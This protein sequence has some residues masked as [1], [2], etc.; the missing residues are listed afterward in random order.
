MTKVQ[1]SM[2]KINGTAIMKQQVF[3]FSGSMIKAVALSLAVF[4]SSA[5]QA[6][7]PV[8][9]GLS[10]TPLFLGFT[11][12]PNVFFVSDDSGSMDWEFMTPPHWRWYN[13]DSD[14]LRAGAWRDE[15]LST[16][17]TNGVLNSADFSSGSTG[18]FNGGYGYIFG[19]SD[20]VY[21]DYRNNN[22]ADCSSGTAYKGWTENCAGGGNHPLDV[23]WRGRA[24][25]LN[26]VYYN[27]NILYEPWDGP[28]D[29]AGTSCADARFIAARSN[30]Y[31]SQPGYSNVRD[32]STDGDA[33]NGAFIYEVW[34]DDSG[35]STAAGQGQ[36][37]AASNFNET[38]YA[39]S[40][41]AN[42]TNSDLTNGEVDLW[43]SHM[44]FIVSSNSVTVRLV[45]YNP[46]PNVN[47]PTRGLNET[48]LVDSSISG[49]A[50]YN[51]LGSVANVK[52]IRDKIV[53]NQAG[54][55]SYIN[56]S[57][58][59]GSDC[60]TIAEATQNIA[61]WYQYYRRRAYV[62]KNAFAEVID[63]QPTFR[64]GL[65][66]L[67]GDDPNNGGIFTELPAK[68]ANLPSHNNQLKQDYFSF[69]QKQAGTPL[70]AALK[71][72]GDYY[73]E[74]S[75]DTRTDPI[76]YSC[77]KNF[78]VLLTDGFWN[79]SNRGTG[80]VDGDGQKNTL[81]D[82]AYTYYKKD[83]SSLPDDVKADLPQESDLTITNGTTFQHMVTFTVA[84]G[85]DGNLRDNDADGNPDKDAAGQDWSVVGIPDKAGNW[86]NPIPSSSSPEKVDDLWH[87][88]YNSAGIFASASSATEV[89]R[90]LINAISAVASRTGSA[91]AVALN[92]G[93]LNA[94]SRL[95]QAKFNS[96]GWSGDILSV[97]IQDGAVDVL[98][99]GSP[100]G[101]DDSPPECDK[102]QTLGELCST[103]WSAAAELAKITYTN[104]K[105]FTLHS[106]LYKGV[107]FDLISS[108]GVSQQADLLKNP[109]SLSQEL[110][111]RGQDRLD[112]I[113][114][115]HSKEADQTNGDF[116]VRNEVFDLSGTT[117]L[118][119]TSLGD[120][121][122]SAPAFVGGPD[123]F[124]PNSIESDSYAKFKFD[125]KNRTGMVY[126]GANDG[127][128]HALNASTGVEEFAYIPAALFGKLSALTSTS[129][130]SQHT[131]YADGSPIVFDAYDTK[132]KTMLA[133]SV[134]GGGQV[135]FGL[136]VTDPD[137]FNAS[138]V[139]W[140][141][142]D[143]PRTVGTATTLYG[144]ADLG[145]TIGN[146]SY[147]KMNNGDWAVIFGN[148]YNNTEK[149]GSASQTGNG[150]IYVVNAFTGALI[151]KF[152]TGIGWAEDPTGGDRPNGV[153]SVTPVDVDGDFKADYLYAGDLF[154]NL[155]KVDVRASTDS[156]WNIANSKAIFTA[157]DANG[158]AQP[159]T[160]AVA[161]KRHPVNRDQTLVLFGTGKYMELTD[162]G[163]TGITTDIQTF[164]GI[165]DDNSGNAA[166]RSNLLQ[167][168]IK[169]QPQ[170]TGLDGVV[171]EFRVTSSETDDLK[172]KIDWTTDKGWYM[173][174][175]LA[176]VA[177]YGEQ[178]V[179]NPILRDNRIIFVTQIPNSG[180]CGAGGSSWIMEL[181]ANDGNRL[182][183]PPFDV[184]GDGIID[185]N[186]VVNYLTSANDTIASGVKSQEGVVAAP[187]ILNNKNAPTEFKYFA[188]TK[189]GVDVVSES[190]N[191]EF[192][193]RQ[194][195]RQL[196]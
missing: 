158:K 184:N 46:D 117:S 174:L 49:S 48:Y 32:L 28:C 27:S 50:C 101:V 163:N 98:P 14:P 70:R 147:A 69:V 3:R 132:W 143:K 119:K 106:D 89:S 140:E 115:D 135:V 61:N 138:K 17:D 24:N 120:I 26:K 121:I 146:V 185:D 134:G 191:A 170:I 93:T 62:I 4:F 71:R 173:D 190:A 18:T 183:V 189:G 38:G 57:S 43:D 75:G 19:N 131:Y 127:M 178:V 87:A 6:A 25:G 5:T 186:D 31:S 125:N 51:I 7:A 129:Y 195:W 91:A 23:D 137:N 8:E 2:E 10:N 130:N 66:L 193:K 114:G 44:R 79:K 95:Y 149:D 162:A 65:T 126:V 36:P 35:Y 176:G 90:K 83:L 153:A 171:R 168:E 64:F 188:G 180:A 151:Q 74:N 166:A 22:T 111:P 84:F 41:F 9:L 145:Y 59:A 123:F 154:G 96:D 172:Y 92:S 67:N 128:L 56:A 34:I 187:G 73:D 139:A 107:K 104:R 103:E 194:S 52:A 99:A 169:L 177:E 165:W 142:T 94:N 150:V 13:Y 81:A 55:A 109:D 72:A 155:W 179:V 181:N 157:L 116:R 53:A 15:G 148:G 37:R 159:I 110:P 63:A 80:D 42:D 82:V 29:P 175:R 97:P 113:R 118:G 60:R 76:I 152:D 136:D 161:V 85:V 30:A 182:L 192:R 68:N 54:A 40:G 33:N 58:P 196:R 88:A 112:Y 45:A 160:S 124:Y 47:S 1:R 102:F 141:F 12:S 105:I 164:Y 39:A 122:H 133:S 77:Q 100:D 78:T 108:L 21:G 20:N 144:D 86:G 11:V 16:R 156:S 167:Q